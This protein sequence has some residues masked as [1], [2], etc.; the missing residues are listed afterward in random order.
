MNFRHTGITSFVIQK[1]ACTPAISFP[2]SLIFPTGIGKMRDPGN[3]V[4]A[5]V[6]LYTF[7]LRIYVFFLQE[8]KSYITIVLSFTVVFVLFLYIFAK[9]VWRK[10]LNTFF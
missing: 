2:G 7:L 8:L 1:A 10:Q 5:P 9:F 6:T 4:D 3:E